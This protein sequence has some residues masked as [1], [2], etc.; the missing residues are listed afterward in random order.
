MWSRGERQHQLSRRSGCPRRHPRPL[1]RSSSAMSQVAARGIGRACLLAEA[2]RTAILV[3]HGR[4][5]MELANFV[6]GVVVLLAAYLDG[7]AIHLR[8]GG[9]HGVDTHGGARPLDGGQANACERPWHAAW[10]TAQPGACAA[11]PPR[12]A[13][14]AHCMSCCHFA[15][16]SRRVGAGRGSIAPSQRRGTP[17]RYRA[18]RPTQAKACALA[19]PE[20]HAPTA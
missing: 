17:E 13:A 4:L 16:Q 1:P 14:A 15:G 10:A 18:A 11:A 5:E 12:N 19:W 8:A 20:Q 9:R 6:A 3:H 2:V 7:A